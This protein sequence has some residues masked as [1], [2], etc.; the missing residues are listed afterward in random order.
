MAAESGLGRSIVID[1]IAPGRHLLLH[2]INPRLCHT[3]DAKRIADPL[4]RLSP[5]GESAP[6]F[7]VEFNELKYAAQL[8]S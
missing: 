8:R 5:I 6:W 3:P 4:S 1:G 2:A 7:F